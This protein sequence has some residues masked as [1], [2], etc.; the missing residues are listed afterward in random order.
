M[1]ISISFDVT[2]TDKLLIRFPSDIGEKMRY[3]E[4]IHSYL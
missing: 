1:V 2:V 3:N 4:T